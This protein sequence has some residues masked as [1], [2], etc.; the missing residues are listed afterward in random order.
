MISYGLISGF[1]AV[2]VGFDTP[3]PKA[4]P[5]LENIQVPNEAE[6]IGGRVSPNSDYE[7]HSRIQRIR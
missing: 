6:T 1:K 5:V 4:E 3:L 7:E 2:T